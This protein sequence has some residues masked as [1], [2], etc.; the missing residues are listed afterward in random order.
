[1]KPSGPLVRRTPLIRR[2]P[3]KPGKKRMKQRH[4]AIGAPTVEQQAHQDAQRAH[5][6]AMCHLL[7]LDFAGLKP[8]YSPCGRTAIHHLNTGDLAGNRQLSQD[9]TVALG[10]YHHQGIP[11]PGFNNASMRAKFGPN[12]H[13]HKRDFLD[14]IALHLVERSVKALQRWQDAQLA[15]VDDARAF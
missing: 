8:G 5:G 15:P 10:D 4:R 11:K 13:D 14:A 9:D 3:L 7:D 2:T 1:M 6:C 12:L